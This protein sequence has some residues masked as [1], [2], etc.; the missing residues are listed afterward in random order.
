MCAGNFSKSLN[1]S[2]TKVRAQISK[3]FSQSILAIST[4]FLY[5]EGFSVTCTPHP[6]FVTPFVSTLPLSF[7]PKFPLQRM[8]FPILP[9]TRIRRGSKILSVETGEERRGIVRTLCTY[10]QISL[11]LSYWM[12]NTSD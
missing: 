6:L 9:R 12:L 10:N 2:L 8:P 5:A 1:K 11:V 4:F 7:I 3:C